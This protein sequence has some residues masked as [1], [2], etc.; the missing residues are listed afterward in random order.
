MI[1]VAQPWLLVL[2]TLW[3]VGVV[4]SLSRVRGMT[5]T[6][7]VLAGIL[8]S[9]LGVILILAMAQPTWVQ[10][11]R[12][13]ATLFVVDRSDSISLT[14]KRRSESFIRDS[15][16]AMGPDDRYGV[17]AF[18]RGPQIDVAPSERSP[19]STIQ[20]LI[21]GGATDIAA[22]LRLAAAT[23]PEGKAR[24]IVVLSDGNETLG[25]A[26]EPAQAL[27]TSGAVIDTVMI[28]DRGAAEEVS[29]L[30]LN[31]PGDVRVDQRF[32]L[33]AVFDSKVATR[34]TLEVDINDRFAE[35]IEVNLTPG[36][37]SILIPQRVPREGLLRYRVRVIA[38]RDREARNNV[39]FGFANVRG[40]SRVL[41]MQGEN[42]GDE[43]ATALRRTGIVADVRGPGQF[44]FRTLDLMG[45]DAVILNDIPASAIGER[46]QKLLQAVVR[47]AGIGLAMIG[48]ENSFLPGGWYGTP[49]AEALPVDLN[50]RQRRTFPSTSVAILVDC[51][52]SMSAIED[53]VQ[54]LQ[55]AIRAAE[56]T[57]QL[58]G[59]RDRISV[60][61]SSDGIE[62]VVRGQELS[63]R[64]PVIQQVRRL[65]VSGGGIYIG[66]TVRAADELMRSEPSKVRHVIILADGADSTDFGDAMARAAAMR[67]AKIT[68]SIV[69]IGNGP[70][71]P[72]LRR[73]AAVGGGNFYLATR[74][75]QLPAIFTQDTA[76]MA[77]SAIEEGDF[78]AIQTAGD[79]ILDGVSELPGYQAYCLAEPRPLAKTILK[80][81]KQDPLL[82]RG[83][84]G[85]GST[86]V[87]TSDAQSRWAKA[88]IGWVG[89]DAF[90][91]QA[92]RSILRRVS[93]ARYQP[94][95]EAKNGQ[96]MLTVENLDDLT[97]ASTD[98]RLSAR[99][100]SP[101]G[102]GEAVQLRKTGPGE[103][104]APLAA[105]QV[106]TYLLS[107][108]DESGDAGPS[109][110]T[111]AFGAA[112]PAEYRSIGTNPALLARLNRL[113]G[114]RTLS[115]AADAFRAAQRPGRSEQPLISL[116]LSIACGLMLLDIAVRRLA[117]SP[118]EVKQGFLARVAANRKRRPT[119]TATRIQVGLGKTKTESPVQTPA[120]DPRP[121]A[122]P[123]ASAPK[124]SAPGKAAA[125]SLLESRRRKRTENSDDK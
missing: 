64:T 17:I 24:R 14:E 38:D 125:T 124:P 114:G 77:R 85:L 18:G 52:G 26:Q 23:F 121:D 19:H 44:P 46:D 21:D 78:H 57:I 100:V 50:I 41:V 96:Y 39:A 99:M 110:V 2:A 62:W 93:D 106:G 54:K 89:F 5:R 13:V 95:V 108:V 42:A 82:V 43:L 112:Y 15:I 51:S 69:S 58:L 107:L 87:F 4:L 92:I 16:K 28:G 67:A 11:N 47:E 36:R 105:D 8:R 109:V 68:T 118:I 27:A 98:S 97:D 63:D 119:A 61:G 86:L 80:T 71:V 48:G 94:R 113:T 66:P 104:A 56:R 90:W 35:R 75:S 33:R 111:T 88:W 37:N 70:Y 73:L 12:G 120:A 10:S 59:P 20:S 123:R 32:E 22:A 74:A 53:G 29:A 76:L 9:C 6:R 34:A 116:L 103:Y 1:L 65:E 49:I 81:P 79:K 84:Y 7:K 55:L 117:F 101:D 102:S 115:D 122:A 45:F 60:A 72:D 31:V 91:N 40:K 30:E 25:D 3:V 83:Q